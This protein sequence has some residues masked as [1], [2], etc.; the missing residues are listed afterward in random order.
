MTRPDRQIATSQRRRSWVRSSAK[1]RSTRCGTRLASLCRIASIAAGV[2]HMLAGVPVTASAGW[3]SNSPQFSETR[4]T[5]QSLDS[6]TSQPKFWIWPMMWIG[7]R[8]QLCRVTPP[9][10]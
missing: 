2:N 1:I 4:C 9:S 10:G 3:P 7:S 8:S 5:I 6:A